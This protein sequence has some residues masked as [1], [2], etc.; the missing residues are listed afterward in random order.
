MWTLN[1]M[2]ILFL[3][4]KIVEYGSLDHLLKN[5][6]SLIGVIM[7]QAEDQNVAPKNM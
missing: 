6:D 3:F 5:E 1:V 7:K 2:M 4:Q